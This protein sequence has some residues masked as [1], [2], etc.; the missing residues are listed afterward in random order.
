MQLVLSNNRVIAHNET[1]NILSYPYLDTTHT[2]AGVTA[3]DNGD[4]SIT[5]T[6]TST[7]YS[8]LFR[9]CT[10]SEQI[11]Y[12]VENIPQDFLVYI[13]CYNSS[14]SWIKDVSANDDGIFDTTTVE[15]FS[16]GELRIFVNASKTFNVTFTPVLKKYHSFISMGGTVVDTGT[17]KVYQN[18][19]VAE[20]NGCPSD[21]DSVGYEYVGGVFKPCA[22]FGKGDNNGYF[23]EACES[24]ATPRNSGIPI[25][26]GLTLENL[27]SEVADRLLLHSYHP[28]PTLPA[29]ATGATTILYY[30]NKFWS[31]KSVSDYSS[32]IYI[33]TDGY[34]WERLTTTSFCIYEITGDGGR[35]V[36]KDS[37]N[38]IHTSTDGI[39]WTKTERKFTDWTS[40]ASG[41][42][43]TIGT[44]KYWDWGASSDGVT[45]ST[46]SGGASYASY[47]SSVAFSSL[48]N[49]FVRITD[50]G[51]IQYTYVGATWDNVQTLNE[52]GWRI[53]GCGL[54]FIAF[55]GGKT[56]YCTTWGTWN[57]STI[58]ANYIY[59]IASGNGKAV[60]TGYNSSSDKRV[61]LYSSD[62]K[63]WTTAAMPFSAEWTG[64]EYAKGLFV[65]V[66]GDT[67]RCAISTDGVNWS[68]GELEITNTNGEDILNALAKALTTIYGL[69]Y[70]EGVNEA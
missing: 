51:A 3:T 60:V 4:G 41:R 67:A 35:L 37:N 32:D 2:T 52:T 33:S 44:G 55:N 57:D 61:V 46:Y 24:C 20:C 43:V 27:K 39:N 22:P 28:I 1:K 59:S 13:Q 21:I 69:A 64:V 50:Y 17:C 42:G 7:A 26:N 12:T 19:T 70:Q 40:F 18:A 10:L 47:D 30:N 8:R 56:K 62:L 65:A 31:I 23:M 25:K 45:W 9:L 48:F 6:G 5:V 29:G 38:Y 16:H 63:T 14:S 58:S 54:G 49:R 11:K 66:A 36:V 34:S 15:G 53:F 68:A